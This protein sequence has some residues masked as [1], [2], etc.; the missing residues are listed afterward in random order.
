M[1]NWQEIDAG[2]TARYKGREGVFIVLC[3]ID[4]R[5][6]NCLI[7]FGI[8]PF[9]YVLYVTMMEFSEKYWLYCYLLSCKF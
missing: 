2:D 4:K 8:F 7:E 5:I 6:K 1:D 3:K 9:M